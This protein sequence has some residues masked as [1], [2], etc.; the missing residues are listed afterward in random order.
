MRKYDIVDVRKKDVIK[1]NGRNV[2]SCL[3]LV[4]KSTIREDLKKI[5]F[6]MIYRWGHGFCM[7]WEVRS[8]FFYLLFY[9]SE[10]SENFWDEAFIVK[11]R[12]SYRGKFH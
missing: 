4:L 11:K 12:L 10:Q 8:R 5:V 1:C 6:K 9:V 2:L 7:I 3:D